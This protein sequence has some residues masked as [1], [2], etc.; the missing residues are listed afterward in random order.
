MNF[1][2]ILDGVFDEGSEEFDIIKTT[3]ELIG[4]SAPSI[5]AEFKTH[6]I[7]LDKCKINLSTMYYMIS[8]NISKKK[9][10][11]SDTYNSTYT[12]LVKLGRP[13]AA[14]IEAEIKASNPA[15]SGLM[16]EVEKLEQ[17]KDLIAS[18]LRCIDSCKQTITELLRDSRRID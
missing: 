16:I 1:K 7:L 10:V 2:E 8:R 4:M 17:V 11:F 5:S 15:Y 9:E 14:A 6:M 12:R 13:S 3:Y 18:Y